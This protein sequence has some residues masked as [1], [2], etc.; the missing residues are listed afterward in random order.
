MAYLIVFKSNKRTVKIQG[1][2]IHPD[3]K[4]HFTGQVLL[5][6]R[7]DRIY[8]TWTIHRDDG[9]FL[10]S[11]S[12]PVYYRV[13]PNGENPLEYA[14]NHAIVGIN[15]YRMMRRKAFQVKNGHWEN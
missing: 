12:R 7:E 8:Y 4:A 11:V 10:A 14:L 9:T 5:E 6:S 1:T 3:Y 2:C 15:R 13:I